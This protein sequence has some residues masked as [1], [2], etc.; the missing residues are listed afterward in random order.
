MAVWKHL[1]DWDNLAS[2]SYVS[3]IQGQAYLDPRVIKVLYYKHFTLTMG[4]TSPGTAGE[5]TKYGR[6]YIPVDKV[7][8]LTGP[9]TTGVRTSGSPQNEQDKIY[10]GVWTDNTT[11]DTENPRINTRTPL[12]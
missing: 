9:T 2:G 8:R 11:A 5:M 4:G 3:S 12:S 7:I 1:P 6:Y 10:F